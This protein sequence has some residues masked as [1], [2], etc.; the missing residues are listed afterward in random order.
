MKYLKVVR[1]LVDEVMNKIEAMIKI[2]HAEDLGKELYEMIDDSKYE[3]HI[4]LDKHIMKDSEKNTK[5]NS[6]LVNSYTTN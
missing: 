1:I 2:N 5:T 3:E 6:K 4:N